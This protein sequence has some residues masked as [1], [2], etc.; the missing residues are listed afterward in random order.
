MSI[1]ASLPTQA[2]IFDLLWLIL[3]RFGHEFRYLFGQVLQPFQFS[4]VLLNVC[5]TISG[6]N[7]GKSGGGGVYSPR[8]S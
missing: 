4:V 3:M 8:H 2:C 5:G 6:S 1:C 7:V